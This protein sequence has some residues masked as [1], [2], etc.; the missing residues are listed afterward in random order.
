MKTVVKKNQT[1][2]FASENFI[3]IDNEKLF[4][5]RGG[6]SPPDDDIEDIIITTIIIPEELKK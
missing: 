4:Q 6:E 1:R 3:Q 5:L 2:T